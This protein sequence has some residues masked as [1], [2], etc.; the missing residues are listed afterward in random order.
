M[1]NRYNDYAPFFTL[2]KLRFEVCSKS[3]IG[4]ELV[5]ANGP[6]QFPNQ[7]NTVTVE[8]AKWLTNFDCRTVHGRKMVDGR[9]VFGYASVRDRPY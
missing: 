1:V 9:N 3:F 5:R 6:S 2:F 4:M 7:S 8:K